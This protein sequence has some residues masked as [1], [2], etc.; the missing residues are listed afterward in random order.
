MKLLIA[1]INKRDIRRLQEGLVEAGFRFTE[2]SSTGGFL[3]EGNVTILMGVDA[4]QVATALDLVR[5]HCESR[6]EVIDAAQPDTRLHAAGVAE[7][8]TAWVGGAVVYVLDVASV[9][10]V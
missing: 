4:D 1:V 5:Q 3:G 10:Q 9:V 7:A 2:I 8:M 6:E